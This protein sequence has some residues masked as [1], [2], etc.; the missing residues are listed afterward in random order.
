M[1]NLRNSDDEK[2]FRY[3]N[4]ALEVLNLFHNK[5]VMVY[6]EGDDDV[7]FWDNFINLF[8][9]SAQ[10]EQVNGKENLQPYIESIIKDD[11]HIIVATD[12]D[13]ND[14]F[15]EKYDH[16]LIMYTYGYSI[17][18]TLY[19]KE[20]IKNTICTFLKENIDLKREITLWINDFEAT[21]HPLV[22]HD[23]A[24]IKFGK[25]TSVMGDVCN[26][27]LPTKKAYNL[28]DE[29]I[30]EFLDQK[31]EL[32][33]ES[34]LKEIESYIDS[35]DKEFYCIIKGHFITNALINVSI[36]RR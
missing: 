4:D 34:E 12:A 31:K 9:Y 24:N 10:V 19:C 6:V 16:P 32:F 17:E 25:S 33:S 20:N 23:A 1:N 22:M 21:C 11:T 27:F 36:Q 28:S 8:G 18:N 5:D 35:Y 3:S 13:Y 2:H 26:R 29:K 15:G 30:E 7:L 14:L